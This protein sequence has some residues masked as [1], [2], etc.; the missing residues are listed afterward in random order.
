MRRAT[1]AIEKAQD[2]LIKSRDS[3]N[4]WRDF[5]IR[6]YGILVDWIT[7]YTGFALA[8]SG[9]TL[10]DLRSSAKELVIRQNSELGG[11]SCD[12]RVVPDTD[13]T[14][15]AIM[16]LSRF[17]YENE[18]SDARE[19]LK[20]QQMPNGSFRTYQPDLIAPFIPGLTSEGWSCG[21]PEVTA[22]A[23]RALNGDEKGI[24]YLKRSAFP[25][26]GWREYWYNKDIYVNAH[27][28]LALEDTSFAE[29]IVR[30]TQEKLIRSNPG[31]SPFYQSL[32]I[33]GNST[34][35]TGSGRVRK[36][37]DYLIEMQMED[38]SWKSPEMLQFPLP[39]NTN[40]W[41]DKGRIREDLYDQKRIFTTATCLMGL[42]S[43]LNKQ[44]N[45]EIAT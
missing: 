12:E 30:D 25:E 29:K 4:L 2:F 40:P 20:K 43:I 39:P 28:I 31:D 27:G 42:S 26:G 21:I 45:G 11:W 3:D 36:N 35:P 8:E 15:F 16:F 38:G 5:D 17:G 1:Q 10:D 32:V 22:T 7:A 14:A 24:S 9:M 23:S 44:T 6:N 41:T 33:L 13:T 19:F 34:H 18:I 37:I